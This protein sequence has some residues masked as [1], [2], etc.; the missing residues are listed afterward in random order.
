MLEGIGTGKL[1]V[2]IEPSHVV[3]LSEGSEGILVVSESCSGRGLL[4]KEVSTAS[5]VIHATIAGV[6]RKCSVIIAWASH[7]R[8]QWGIAMWPCVF[9]EG[10]VIWELLLLFFHNF[11]QL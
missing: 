3:E 9:S 6:L 2:A 7:F 4:I 11:Y 10:V 5:L 1:A 8:E